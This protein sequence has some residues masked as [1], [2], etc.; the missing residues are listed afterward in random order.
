MPVGDDGPEHVADVQANPRICA[1]VSLDDARRR[2]DTLVVNDDVL[3]VGERLLEHAFDAF[4]QVPLAVEDRGDN[5]YERRGL[6]RFDH[7][8]ILVYSAS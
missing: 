7:G 1:R 3:P 6:L 2:I 5:A 8:R 4:G